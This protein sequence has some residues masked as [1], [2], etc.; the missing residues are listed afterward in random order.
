[1]AD[2][3]ERRFLDRASFDKATSWIDAHGSKLPAEE[4]TISEAAGRVL[5]EPIA[6]AWPI[7]PAD[8]ASSDGYAVRSDDTVGAGD[9]NP[10]ALAL[11]DCNNELPPSAAAPIAAG[12]S[13]PRGADAILP[14]E[15][16]RATGS[17]LE[18]FSAV[19][20]G[21]GV[22]REGQQF[23]AGTALLRSSQNASATGYRP[24]RLARN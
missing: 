20:Q 2:I 18:V 23:Q 4:I 16:A 24:H 17:T 12:A 5:A 8:R 15:S 22:E 3:R 19:A 7:P 6:A 14:F 10:L 9:Y 21:R 1:M 11:C 13:L